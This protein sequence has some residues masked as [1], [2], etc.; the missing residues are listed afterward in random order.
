MGLIETGRFLIAG[1]HIGSWSNLR[2]GKGPAVKEK[3]KGNQPARFR[4][5]GRIATPSEK[6][7]SRRQERE[8]MAGRKREGKWRVVGVEITRHPAD[9]GHFG[10]KK[11]KKR[12]RSQKKDKPGMVVRWRGQ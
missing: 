3:A 7:S 12:V 10:T 11:Q 5:E 6:A 9:I 1:P 8:S 4:F 2:P